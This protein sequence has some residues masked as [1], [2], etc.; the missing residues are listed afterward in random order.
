MATKSE[1]ISQV[2]VADLK[3]E[4]W[5]EETRMLIETSGNPYALG[6]MDAQFREIGEAVPSDSE[7]YREFVIEALEEAFK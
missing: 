4:N 3:D 7:D 2:E 6:Y 5:V 1:I